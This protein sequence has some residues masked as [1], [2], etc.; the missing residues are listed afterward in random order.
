MKAVDE[1][2]RQLIRDLNGLLQT[3][4]AS[5]A[6]YFSY[7]AYLQKKPRKAPD[8]R[9]RGRPKRGRRRKRRKRRNRRKR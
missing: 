6:L 3:L 4:I 9:K 7:Q 2:L 8:K 1:E 5:L